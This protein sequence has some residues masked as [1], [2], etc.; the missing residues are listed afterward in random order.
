MNG[1][2]PVGVAANALVRTLS[3]NGRMGGADGADAGRYGVVDTSYIL[4]G[5]PMFKKMALIVKPSPSAAFVFLDES[6][7]TLDDGYFAV[8]L[9]ATWQNSP[10]VRHS[11]G[12]T[13]S[14]ADGHSERW[15]WR[16]LNKEQTYDVAATASTTADLKRMQDAVAVP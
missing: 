15:R 9:T 13:F 4:P 14:F 8:R 5:Y 6:L 7:N 10:T 16:G 3:M 2:A 1:K 11:Q 12:S